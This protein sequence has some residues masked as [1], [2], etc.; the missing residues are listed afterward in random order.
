MDIVPLEFFIPRMA[1]QAIGIAER[2][3]EL[4][5]TGPGTG[6]IFVHVL[7]TIHFCLCSA[8]DSI[9]DVTG[10]AFCFANVAVLVMDRG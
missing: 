3:I 7:E 1:M 9:A 8:V 4:Y 2:F 5:R 10:V 6:E